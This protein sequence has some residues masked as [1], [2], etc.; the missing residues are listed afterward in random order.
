VLRDN[1]IATNALYAIKN[2]MTIDDPA[3][4]V[5]W[6]SPGFNNVPAMPGCRNGVANQTLNTIVT[7]FTTNGGTDVKGLNNVFVFSTNDALQTCEENLPAW[8]WKI[9]FYTP[10]FSRFFTFLMYFFYTGFVIKL[11][12]RTYVCLPS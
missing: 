8:Y 9:L 10:I 11:V 2:M 1:N 3:I 4:V 12:F 6:N 7:H 5:Q